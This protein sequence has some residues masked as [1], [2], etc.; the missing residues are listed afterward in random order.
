MQLVGYLDSPFVRRV[1]ISM[2]YLGIAYAHREL[3]I[4]RNYEEFRQ[5]HPA[6]KVPTLVLDNGEVMIDSSIIIQYLE[7]QVARRSLMPAA[8]DEY[9]KASQQV[10]NA[11]VVMEKVAQLIYETGQR[12]AEKQHGPWK[13]RI[14]QQLEGA[15]G[16]MEAA[17]ASNTG[18]GRTWLAGDLPGQ[19]DISTAVAWRFVC[20]IDAVHLK[21]EDFPALV[22]HSRC[23]EQQRE[24]IACPLSS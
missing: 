18:S 14:R 11:L 5:L 24:F 6:V 22:A 10:G 12:P 16:L 13:E 19:A 23:A 17:V 3:S 2:Q 21:P 20:H 8:A 9:R 1:A 15:V 7:S 4:F